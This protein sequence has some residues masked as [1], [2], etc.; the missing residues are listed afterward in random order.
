MAYDYSDVDSDAE[1]I[2][3][4]MDARLAALEARATSLIVSH[5]VTLE[6]GKLLTYDLIHP[7]VG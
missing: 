3:R 2:L 6:D 4:D 1:V 5:T 7:P